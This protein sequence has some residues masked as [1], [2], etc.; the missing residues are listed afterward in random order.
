MAASPTTVES[1]VVQS[2]FDD[3]EPLPLLIQNGDSSKRSSR[4]DNLSSNDDADASIP[5]RSFLVEEESE[6]AMSHDISL[7]EILEVDDWTLDLIDDPDRDVIVQS[8]HQDLFLQSINDI[9][10]DP[11]EPM[12]DPLNNDAAL[13]KQIDKDL[14]TSLGE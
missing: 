12:P 14:F 5:V 11:N 4:E 1:V 8:I 7:E 9:L 2:S 6:G 3:I 13:N 10:A